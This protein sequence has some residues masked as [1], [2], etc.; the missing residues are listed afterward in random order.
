[1]D[2]ISWLRATAIVF[3]AAYFGAIFTAPLPE[4]A[5]DDA[6]VVGLLAAGDLVGL[7]VG[8]YLLVTAGIAALTFT[9]L[10]TSSM[11]RTGLNDTGT[12]LVRSLGTAYGVLVMVS[13]VLFLAVPMGHVVEELP[14]ATP[15]PFRE[16]TMA[17]F[18][19]LLIPALLCA[20]LMVVVVSLMLRRSGLAAPWC[21]TPGFI[22]APLLLVGVGW[23][24]QFLFPLWAVLVAFGLRHAPAT[25]GSARAAREA[26][27]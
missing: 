14:E 11:R 13:A 18:A 3:A 12:S 27:R 19:A 2:T 23:A 21:T 9:S 6:R 4:G 15:S 1:M 22:I 17:G 26:I 20:A 7:V 8:G 16:L 10:L 25:E 24:P 5:Y